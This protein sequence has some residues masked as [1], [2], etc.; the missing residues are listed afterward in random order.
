METSDVYGKIMRDVKKL[1][2]HRRCDRLNY[3]IPSSSSPDYPKQ[4]DR[5]TGIKYCV[6]VNASTPNSVRS[7][8]AK[9]PA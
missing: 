9:I 7:C 3:A 1:H 4:S 6:K 5:T 8:A 2:I